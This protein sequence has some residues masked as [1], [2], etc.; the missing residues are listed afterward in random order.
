MQDIHGKFCNAQKNLAT[1][2][3]HQTSGTWPSFLAG[4]HDPFASIQTSKEARPSLSQPL[5]EAQTWFRLQKEEAL[6]KIIALKQ[7]EAEY[8]ENLSSPP[9]IRGRCSNAL[10]ND[11]AALQKALGK[12]TEDDGSGKGINVPQFFKSEFAMSK[13]L[14]ASWVA[15][16]WDFTRIKSSKLSKELEKKKELA[17]QA[18]DAMDTGADGTE[19][20]SVTVQKAVDAALRLQNKSVKKERGKKKVQLPQK[21]YPIA[22]DS[23]LGKRKEPY[24]DE[25]LLLRQ[26]PENTLRHSQGFP[27]KRR[28]T[29]TRC[30]RDGFGSFEKEGQEGKEDFIRSSR[31]SVSNP[32][33]IPREILDLAP[34]TALSII[35]SRIPLTTVSKADVRIKLGPGV[36]PIPEKIDDFLSLG[37]RFLLPPVFNAA[38]PVEAFSSL[39]TRIKWKVFFAHKQN[40]SDFLDMNPQYRIPK[41]ETIAVPA[42]TPKW[43]EDMLDRGRTELLR[44]IGA[45][46]D[47][48]KKAPVNP[49]YQRDLKNLRNWRNMN[50]YLVLQ[51]DKNLGTTIVCS[52][53]Y[54]E[55]LDALV[56]NNSGFT[57]IADYHSKFIPVFDEIRK[58][59]NKHLPAEVKDFILASCNIGDIVLPRFHGL[60]KI[61]KEPWALRPIVPCHSYPLANASKVLSHFLKL[62]VRESPWIL[63]STQDLA[64]LLEKIRIPSDKKYYLCTGDVVAM[65]PNIPRQRAHQILGDIARAASNE[66]EYVNLITKLAQWSDNY[67]VFEHKNRYFHQK[68]GLAMGIPAAPDV[69]NLYMSHFENSFASGFILYKRYLD[70]IIIL[71]EAVSKKDALEQCSKVRADGL[72][73][74]W[75][76]E[77]KAVNFL[78][79]TVS[80]EAGYLSFK[81]YRKPLNSYERL[82]FTSAHPLHVKRAAF[83]GE[84]SRIARLCSRYNTYYTEIAHV[85]DIYLR[86]GYPGALLHNWIRQ[87]ARNRWDSRYENKKEALEG[88]PFWLKSVYNDVW[89]HVDL[90]KVWSAMEDTLNKAETP[91]AGYDSIKLSLKKFRNLGEINNAMNADEQRAFLSEEERV[92]QEMDDSDSPAEDLDHNYRVH[93][94]W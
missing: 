61:H 11:W 7:A 94:R 26:N 58:C 18:T 77:E 35:Q 10:D 66:P 74:T 16:S 41:P 17:Q 82:P 93:Y 87:E 47:S 80:L 40:P 39:C 89:K 1:L 42:T 6:C 60:P 50:N 13:D 27:E 48:T 54:N 4:M 90:R 37:H 21:Q 2:H 72:T 46:P 12:F 64:R 75:T 73:F 51:S 52:K 56:L 9:V 76:V 86:R 81:P 25:A 36:T 78:D 19:A 28:K 69:A 23:S 83:L 33:S 45:I 31:W 59:T 55:K 8:L 84:V 20:L 88:S 63:E 3:A 22:A 32:S 91:L 65:Y 24:R 5:T 43:V 49:K 67:L 53:W 57:E 14:V 92:R 34:E 68:E 62:R 44:Q 85:R 29:E 70:D 71:V 38:L 30:K 79:L 15:K